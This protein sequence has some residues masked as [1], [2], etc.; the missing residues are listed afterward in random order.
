MSPTMTWLATMF[1]QGGPTMYW[2]E[3]LGIAGVVVVLVHLFKPQPWSLWAS[4]AAIVL[5]LASGAYGT[6]KGR[7]MTDEGVEM[8]AHPIDDATPT[9]RRVVPPAELDE[10][11]AAGYAEAMRPIQFAGIVAGGLAL[12]LAIGELRRRATAG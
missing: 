7:S 2:I 12:L 6:L 4:L 11:R 1:H 3:Y 5:V 9:E 10:M 8:W